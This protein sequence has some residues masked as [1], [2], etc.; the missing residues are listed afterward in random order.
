MLA[1]VRG[2]KWT[3][4]VAVVVMAVAGCLSACAPSFGALCAAQAVAGI[5]M[6]GAMVPFDLLAELAPPGTRGAVVNVSACFW[7]AGTML[8]L[9]SAW[10]VLDAPVVRTP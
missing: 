2:R 8:V 9:L 1:D 4:M 3:T 10:L 6:G 5:G 7:A